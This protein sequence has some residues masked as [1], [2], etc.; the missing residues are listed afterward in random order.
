M[1]H[2]F[3]TDHRDKIPKQK[4]W[5]TNWAEHDERLRGRGDMTVW[6][7]EDALA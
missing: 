5:V 1:P 3:N 6:V 4:Q 2:K 7:S